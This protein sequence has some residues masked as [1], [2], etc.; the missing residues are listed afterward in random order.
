MYINPMRRKKINLWLLILIILFI[1]AIVF[2]FIHMSNSSKANSDSRYNQKNGEATTNREVNGSSI[3][4]IDSYDSFSDVAVTP[5]DSG[6]VEMY[7]EVPTAETPSEN[8]SG[9]S[10]IDPSLASP[11]PQPSKS[12]NITPIT[13]GNHVYTINGATSKK[14]ENYQYVEFKNDKVIYRLNTNATAFPDM[15]KKDNLK[16]Y[17]EETFSVQV[18]SDIKTGTVDEI[19]MIICTIADRSCVGYFIITKL[20]DSEVVCLKVV[21]ADNQFALIQDLSVPIHE[22]PFITANIQ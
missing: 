17:I 19:E 1:T 13:I 8:T 21:D 18:T 11:G 4:K 5:G 10:P 22:I 16:Q 6:S 2:T 15:L 20:N 14:E 12:T 3:G 7:N 9:N